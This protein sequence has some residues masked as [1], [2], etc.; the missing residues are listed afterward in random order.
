MQA[1]GASSPAAVVAPS[2][3]NGGDAAPVP[4]GIGLPTSFGCHKLF[5]YT[6]RKTSSH[7]LCRLIVHNGV[8]MKDVE[9]AWEAPRLLKLRLAWPEWFHFA[10]QMAQFTTDKDGN[11]LFPP[12]HPL[13]MDTNERNQ[14]LVEEDGRIWDEGFLVFEQ[15]MKEENIESEL[16]DVE[17]A[18]QNTTVKVLQL[19]LECVVACYI[20][21]CAFTLLCIFS[22]IVVLLLI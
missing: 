10:E 7:F 8:T 15:D 14:K 9:L 1:F 16:V 18:S 2:S 5:N 22:H 20:S 13:T 17:I 11:L 12:E 19:Y 3:N 6:S 4:S 21:L